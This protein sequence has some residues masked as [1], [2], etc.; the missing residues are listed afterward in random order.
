MEDG[1]FGGLVMKQKDAELIQRILQGDQ[2]AFYAVG[3]QISERG[4][5]ACMAENR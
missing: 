5:R 1:R 4:S 2:D 3:Q